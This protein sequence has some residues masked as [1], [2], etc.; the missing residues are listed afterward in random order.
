MP[1]VIFATPFFTDNAVRNIA[2][3]ADLPDVRLGLI[4]QEP[5]EYLSPAL[6]AKLAAHWRIDDCLNTDQLVWA[7]QSLAQRL[8]PIDRLFGA[9]EQMQ[10][11]LAEARA[12]LGIEGMSVEAARNF[13]EKA[14]MKTLF[15]EAGIPCA[16]H[17]LVANE[18]DAWKFAEEVGYPLVV[19]PPSGAGAQS[20]FRVDDPDALRERLRLTPT[21]PNQAV[22]LEEY[23]T[24]DE[25]SFDTTSIGG[26]A[27]WHSL[28][29][30]LPAPL[31]VMRNPWIQW[32]LILPREVDEPQYDDI[33]QVAFRALKG[34][35]MSTGMSH[36]E[37]FRRRDGSIAISEVAARPPG[38]QITTLISRAHDIDF[39]HAWARLMVYGVFDRPPR[40][41]AAGAAF[42]RGQGQG[43][44]KAIHGL[45]Q[46]QRE[47]G[48]LVTDMKLPQIGQE[49][50]PSY[51]GEGYVI[52]RHPE[53][54]VVEQ[55][56][57]RLI[58]LV[59]IEL[60]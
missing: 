52:M 17:R 39:L 29:Y 42:L 22:L 20:T 15:R 46:A 4:S 10:V 47:V 23:I 55:A 60:G 26:E 13:R 18:A 35:G 51:E 9:V 50:S 2:A 49:P 12:Q 8:G 56:L 48:H 30:Y 5:Q 11:P 43:R 1:V 3:I 32:R 25:H 41:Y 58:T 59:R 53:T 37:W 14:R 40:R 7:A 27:V 54:T 19:K 36:L 31:E 44:V 57:L 6:R 45:D 34:L 28:T 16:R 38:A 21:G 33:R 24:G